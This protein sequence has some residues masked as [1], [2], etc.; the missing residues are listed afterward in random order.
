M[1]QNLFKVL[2][3]EDMDEIL[4]DNSRRIVVV[5]YASKTRGKS[6]KLDFAK[7]AEKNKDT[8]FVYLDVNDY[9]DKT[10]KYTKDLERLPKFVL[11]YNHDMAAHVIGEDKDA[12]IKVLLKVKELIADRLRKEMENKIAL[13]KKMKDDIVEDGGNMEDLAKDFEEETAGTSLRDIDPNI[14]M[15]ELS[16][17]EELT[18]AKL[19]L[20]AKKRYEL[21]QLEAIR[22]KKMELSKMKGHVV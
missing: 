6:M 18:R 5:M 20:E 10:Y 2:S 17:I 21:Q 8:F 7:I 9:K 4:D 16:E 11:Y 19:Q 1:N 22:R 13:A 14:K 3:E 15:K 12:L